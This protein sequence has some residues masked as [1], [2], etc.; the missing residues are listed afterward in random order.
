MKA[1]YFDPMFYICSEKMPFT[2]RILT[3]LKET[4][5]KKS[6]EYA[7]DKAIKRYPYFCIKVVRDSGELLSVPNELPIVVYEGPEVY[8]LGSDEVNRH[9][10]AISF[11]KKEINFYVSHVITDGGGFFPFIKTVLYYYLCNHYNVQLDSTGINLFDDP[12][13][14]DELGNPYPEEKMQNAVPLYEC[15]DK[16]FFRLCDGGYVNDTKQTT[17]HLRIKESDVM[18]FSHDNDGSPC[19]LVSSLMTKAIWDVHKNETKDIVSAVS[20]NLRPGLGNVHNYR[21]L[22]SAIN[23]RY[24]NRMRGSETSKLCTCSRGMITVQSQEENV[25]Y[26][27]KMKKKNLESFFKIPDIETKK[28]V[29]GKIALEDSINNTF[30]VSYVGQ[31]HIECMHK[32]LD[33]I[34]NHTDGSTY[35]TV[36]LEIFPI[37]GWFD[38]AFLQGFSCDVYY[39]AFLKQLELN[40]LTYIE[41][42]VVPIDVPDI[43]LP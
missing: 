10:L 39:K 28:E 21:M 19:V 4:V 20:F 15:P 31:P 11:Y 7:V 43:I 29:L 18:K 9:L 16:D 42:D 40:G 23:L 2:I 22:C 33:A 34:Y 27:A 6:L 14:D 3:K 26:Y 36:F 25:L 32:Y 1:Q 12:M 41:D 13:F 5:D 17:Y 30:S 24:P 38:I 37:D 8:P 35:K